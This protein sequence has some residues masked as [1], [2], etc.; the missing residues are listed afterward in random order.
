MVASELVTTSW[1]LGGSAGRWGEELMARSWRLVCGWW[2]QPG[3]SEQR[4]A[5]VG[6]RL[7]AARSLS[8]RT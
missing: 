4:H 8:F 6:D 5:A 3:S 1:E 7:A 2:Q